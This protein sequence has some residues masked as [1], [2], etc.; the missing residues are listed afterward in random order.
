LAHSWERRFETASWVLVYSQLE[1]LS[2]ALVGPLPIDQTSHLAGAL[3]FFIYDAPKVLLLLTGVVFVVGV[4]RTFG[5]PERTRQLL[6]GRRSGVGNV[7]AASL[8]VVTP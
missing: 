1:P 2:F 7:M 3:Q 4:V 8:G 5:S 6:S